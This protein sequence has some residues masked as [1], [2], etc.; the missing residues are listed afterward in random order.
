MKMN[1]VFNN[2]ATEVTTQK[3]SKEFPRITGQ[4]LSAKK[5][6]EPKIPN[7]NTVKRQH[8]TFLHSE[9]IVAKILLKSDLDRKDCYGLNVGEKYKSVK[10]DGKVNSQPYVYKGGWLG[11]IICNNL[12]VICRKPNLE[13]NN[14][15]IYIY[16]LWTSW[17]REN[18]LLDSPSS[19]NFG[20]L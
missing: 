19:R 13:S 7:R 2:D 6:N 10:V 1:F 15:C 14:F 8:G 18:G 9:P 11:G 3:N 20:K 5:Q 17:L 16:R 4:A 12:F